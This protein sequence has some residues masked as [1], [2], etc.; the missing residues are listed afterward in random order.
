MPID[1][2]LLDILCCPKTKIDVQML[3][4]S[5]LKNLN[6]KIKAKKIKYASGETVDETL[7]EAL[8]T[9]DK[10]SVYRID[11]GIPVMLIDQAIPFDQA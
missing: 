10:K 2:E 9:I 7:E 8:I 6:D 5:Q 11:E 4:H 1:K 3:D